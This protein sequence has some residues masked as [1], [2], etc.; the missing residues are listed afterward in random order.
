MH[1]RGWLARGKD[2]TVLF[3]VSM[4]LVFG[5]GRSALAAAEVWTR[6]DLALRAPDEAE[7][8]AGGTFTSAMEPFGQVDAG[9]R[10]FWSASSGRAIRQRAGSRL[11][12]DLELGDSTY[13]VFIPLGT[14]SADIGCDSRYRVSFRPHGGDA[15]V[16]DERPV[17]PVASFAP[18]TVE[19]PLSSR[20]EAGRLELVVTAGTKPDPGCAELAALWGSP[21]LLDRRP[22]PRRTSLARSNVLMIGID[23]MRADRI[24]PRAEL[25][26]LTPAIDRLAAESDVWRHAYASSNSTNPS[27]LS[28]FTGLYPKR[29]G[30]YDLR[31]ALPE[32]HTTLAE[33]FS[34][35]GY[36]TLAVIAVRHLAPRFS[37]IGQ[38]FQAVVAPE[39]HFTAETVVDEAIR[40]LDGVDEPFFAWLHFFDPHTPTLPPQPWASGRRSASLRGLAPGAE[41]IPFRPPGLRQLSKGVHGHPDLYD[42]EV[43]YLDRQIDRLYGFLEERGLLDNTFIV[44]F[45]DH[46]ESLGEHDFLHKHVGLYEPTIHVPLIIRWPDRHRHRRPEVSTGGQ[47]RSFDGLV[48]TL[49]LFS[50]VLGAT[51]LPVPDGI[52]AKDLYELGESGRAVVFAEHANRFG[53]AI[54]IPRYKLI[55]MTGHPTLPD[56]YQLFDLEN[57]PGETRDLA[58]GQLPAEGQLA[59]HLAEW[60]ADASPIG[61]QQ[62]RRAAPE[63]LERLRALG[64]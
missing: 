35:A 44:L 4:V 9:E 32:E 34:Q 55:R 8:E 37:G 62:N 40:K 31:T 5:G 20:K 58:G 59:A 22:A 45:A 42:A 23:T 21:A 48:Q 49:D 46:G 12:W 11:S 41:W 61:P 10:R 19:V 13:F 26:S 6:T 17:E 56:G 64:Y 50:T 27:F 24:G 38:G 43:A 25:P 16:L 33:I 28:V 2:I 53:S 51:G 52:D 60:T 29:H 47:G 15:T 14:R 57:D 39:G 54:R 30:I 18:E 3:S 1:G 63:D 7:P 36:R